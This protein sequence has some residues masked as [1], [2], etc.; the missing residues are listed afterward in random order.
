MW[1]FARFSC[2]KSLVK[3]M[4]GVNVNVWDSTT[5][6]DLV[7]CSIILNVDA[8]TAWLQGGTVI[9][10]CNFLPDLP[11]NWVSYLINRFVEK[12]KL[13]YSTSAHSIIKCPTTEK[14]KN[15]F[16]KFLLSWCILKV[17]LLKYVFNAFLYLEL[18]NVVLVKG[19]DVCLNS[20]GNPSDLQSTTFHW[21]AYSW[22]LPIGCQ[23]EKNSKSNI[24]ALYWALPDWICHVYIII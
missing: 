19:S 15:I 5:G 11:P 9:C 16:F 24:V 23:D 3:Q 6:R 8:Y 12:K 21:E 14:K 4:L 1:L 13:M 10:F 18:R 20:V 22:I 7:S 2:G 17:T